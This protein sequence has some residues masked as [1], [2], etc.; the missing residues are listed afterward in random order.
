MIA[1][2]VVAT[3]RLVRRDKKTIGWISKDTAATFG[4][5]STIPQHYAAADDSGGDGGSDVGG[6]DGV[7]D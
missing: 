7:G 4:A 3:V 1:G 5:E 2:F 6:G